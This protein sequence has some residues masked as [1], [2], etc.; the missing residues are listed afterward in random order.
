MKKLQLIF[1]L[2]M[3]ILTGCA[4][5]QTEHPYME[6]GINVTDTYL[7]I[8][9]NYVETFKNV[10]R[11]TQKYMMENI[12]PVMNKTKEKIIIYNDLVIAGHRDDERKAEIIVIL[13]ELSAK[14]SNIKEK[15]N[16]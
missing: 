8:Y 10:D 12:A 13:R 2:S 9:D 15:N 1:L 3:F 6:I 14:I 16:E 11:E 4:L 7:N 5:T